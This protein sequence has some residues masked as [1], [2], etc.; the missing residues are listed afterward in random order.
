MAR[1]EFDPGERLE[2]LKARRKAARNDDVVSTAG[3][4]RITGL[5][6]RYLKRLI[7]ENPDF[8]IRK[9]GAEGSSYE[10]VVPD[11]LDWLIGY[12][13]GK[14]QARDAAQERIA[15]LA[16][17]TVPN[18]S[19]NG[20]SVKDFIEINRVQLEV[21]RRKVEQRQLVPAT[22]VRAIMSG[23]AGVVQSE[24]TTMVSRIDPAGRWPAD[25]R[26]M[27]AEELRNL[28]VRI[29]DGFGEWL[30]SDVR[31][32]NGTGSRSRATKRRAVLPK[33]AGNSTGA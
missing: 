21:Q 26:A 5:G 24:L 9:R 8:P 16:G 25:A 27:I 28:L 11:V 19:T 3:L 4:E 20:L 32:T 12:Y 1:I 15:R 10:F 29:H 30:D 23:L 14:V 17:I 33:R 22:E 7:D 13:R 6:W 31:G 18:G 2:T